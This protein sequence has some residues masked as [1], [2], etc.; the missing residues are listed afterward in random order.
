MSKW[1]SAGAMCC[2]L[3][4]QHGEERLWEDAVAARPPPTASHDCEVL[5]VACLCRI[6]S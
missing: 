1:Q 4:S 6:V 5:I 2:E 3:S